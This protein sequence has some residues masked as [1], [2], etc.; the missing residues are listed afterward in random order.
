M[1]VSNPNG[2]NL[3]KAMSFKNDIIPSRFKP[4]RGKFTPR[5]CPILGASKFVSN[6]NGVNLH[7]YQRCDQDETRCFKPQRGKFTPY[8]LKFDLYP[9]AGFKPQRGK[10]TL[11]L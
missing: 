1:T 11:I 4:Q 5:K 7:I 9:Y 10:F 3:H 2:V 8:D 6:P